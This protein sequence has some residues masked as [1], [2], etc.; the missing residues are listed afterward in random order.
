MVPK[1]FEEVEGVEHR[2][3][4]RLIRCGCTQPNNAKVLENDSEFPPLDVRLVESR[5][6]V[7]DQ[8]KKAAV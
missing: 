1:G 2:A 5:Q 3:E 7:E 4:G 8:R 6:T